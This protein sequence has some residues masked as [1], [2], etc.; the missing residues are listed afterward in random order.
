MW[1]LVAERNMAI[2]APRHPQSS[3]M[4]HRGPGWDGAV[5]GPG[6]PEE[7]PTE[8]GEPE[9]RTIRRM[10]LWVELCLSQKRYV[11]VLIPPPLLPVTVTL[12]GSRVFAET[13]ELR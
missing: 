10:L 1:H 7:A 6:R 4:G 12:F 13:M 3:G 5:R 2:P 11:E 9:L 8:E